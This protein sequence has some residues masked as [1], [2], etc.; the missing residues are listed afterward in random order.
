MLSWILCKLC[1]LYRR[2]SQGLGCACKI[3]EK[4]KKKPQNINGALPIN[5]VQ[6]KC[7]MLKRTSLH[8][9]QNGHQG[10]GLWF[11]FVQTVSFQSIY[12]GAQNVSNLFVNKMVIDSVTSL[13]YFLT[14]QT[15]SL[16]WMEWWN[17]IHVTNPKSRDKA[18][19]FHKN[20]HRI[21][22]ITI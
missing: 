17:M 8:G 3:R 10:F 16:D 7:S 18:V 14:S 12:Y 15:L 6:T 5:I 19:G 21:E 13:K 9:Q 1:I 11:L 4:K 20:S 22:N 2:L